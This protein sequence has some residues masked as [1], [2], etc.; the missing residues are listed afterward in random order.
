MF[1]FYEKNL[2]AFEHIT[3]FIEKIDSQQILNNKRSSLIK[4][5]KS[6]KT[7]VNKSY[8]N[9]ILQINAFFFTIKVN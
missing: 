8:I 6:Q 3:L 1:I 5:M 2:I 9:K 4:K 7:L